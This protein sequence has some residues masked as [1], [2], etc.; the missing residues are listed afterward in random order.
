MNFINALGNLKD[1]LLANLNGRVDLNHQQ[2][3]NPNKKQVTGKPV[4]PSDVPLFKGIDVDNLGL[5]LKKFYNICMNLST[6]R[7]TEHPLEEGLETTLEEAATAAADSMKKLKKKKKAYSNVWKETFSTYQYPTG[8]APEEQEEDASIVE[9]TAYEEEIEYNDTDPYDNRWMSHPLLEQS[10]EMRLAAEAYFVEAKKTLKKLKRTARTIKRALKPF[11]SERNI[12]LRTWHNEGLEQNK[13]R[14]A[15]IQGDVDKI[16]FKHWKKVKRYLKKEFKGIIPSYIGSTHTGH[17]SITKAYI[18][19]N[20]NDYDVD[21]QLV[22]TALYVAITHFRQ[23]ASKERLFVREV[24]ESVSTVIEVILSE[25]GYTRA[26]FEPD[27]TNENMVEEFKRIGAQEKTYLTNLKNL[28]DQ[29]LVYV[30]AVNDDLI[31]LPGIEDDKDDPFDLAI[32]RARGDVAPEANTNAQEETGV[33]DTEEESDDGLNTESEA[34]D[35]EEEDVE[36]TE[37]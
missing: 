16:L 18:Q 23:I 35:S 11:L 33:S 8:P 19:F 34:E 21:G 25:G 28:M 7:S 24:A 37:I 22:S 36:A 10:E 1:S 6:Y 30:E 4:R 32:V 12:K 17:K 31:K 20:P 13:T 2:N 27:T 9:V 5:Q 15:T 14:L 29:L 3:L 26:K